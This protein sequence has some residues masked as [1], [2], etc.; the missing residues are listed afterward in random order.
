MS[1]FKEYIKIDLG[2]FST[3]NGLDIESL[4]DHTSNMPDVEG[5]W[6]AGGAIRRFIQK[7]ALDTDFDYFFKSKKVMDDWISKLPEGL[8]KIKETK[9]HIHFRGVIAE[10]HLPIDVQAI[11]FKYY[12]SPK[13]VIDSF[14]YTIT[15]FILSESNVICSPESLWDLARMKLVVHKVTYPVSTMRRMIKYTRQGFTACTGCLQTFLGEVITLSQTDPDF[16]EK[17]KIEYID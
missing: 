16:M 9:H 6:L 15:Q 1:E 3:R 7:K 8:E 11:N 5:A 10:N 12:K 13:E 4:N 14:D 2:Y 17:M